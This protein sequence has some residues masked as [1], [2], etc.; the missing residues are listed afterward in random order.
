[1]IRIPGSE[2]PTDS[3]QMV[4]KASA[5]YMPAAFKFHDMAIPFAGC[6]SSIQGRAWT[7]FL[8]LPLANAT[9][10]FAAPSW[11]GMTFMQRLLPPLLLVVT[12]AAM[13]LVSLTW[14]PGEPFAAPLRRV[15]GVVSAL[16]LLLSVKGARIFRHVGTNIMTFD[17][18]DKLVTSGLFA[19]SRNPMYLGFALC[20]LGGAVALGAMSAVGIAILFCITLDRWY[21]GFEERMMRETFGAEYDA[22]CRKVRRWL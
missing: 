11:T 3:G 19:W 17:K 16:G 7:G 6:F 10:W 8:R 4:W 22:Y 21:V 20:A 2:I 15:G 14:P 1:M 9:P 5:V 12:W 18:P 13:T